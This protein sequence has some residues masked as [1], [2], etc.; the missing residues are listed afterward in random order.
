MIRLGDFLIQMKS[1]QHFGILVRFEYL[2]IGT[3][4]NASSKFFVSC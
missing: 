4:V 3:T 1:G 2:K